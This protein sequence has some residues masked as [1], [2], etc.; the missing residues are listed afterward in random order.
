MAKKR[1]A[2]LA[3]IG[4][5]FAS[6]MWLF[7]F[8]PK[9]LQLSDSCEPNGVLNAIRASVQGQRFWLVQLAAV[10]AAID[11][12]RELREARARADSIARPFLAEAQRSFDSLRASI[13]VQLPERRPSEVLRERAESLASAETM[14]MLDSLLA[15]RAIRFSLCRSQVASRAGIRF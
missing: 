3:A 2:L 10:D 11:S 15:D 13:P 14:E 6:G 7:T 4:M 5:I 8:T 9:A 1:T 12:P